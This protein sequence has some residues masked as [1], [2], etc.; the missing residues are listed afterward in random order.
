M[1]CSMRALTSS[2]RARFMRCMATNAD[3]NKVDTVTVKYRGKSIEVRKGARLRTALLKNGATPHNEGAVYINCRGIGS[4]GTCAVEICG[5][6]E[7]DEPD[8]EDPL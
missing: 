5:R 3:S 1:V 8:R 7:T 6:Q 2:T 4:C